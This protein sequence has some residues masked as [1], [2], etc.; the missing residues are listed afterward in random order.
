[1]ATKFIQNIVNS[2]TTLSNRA[3]LIEKQASAA[4]QNIVTGLELKV[5]EL[6]SKVQSLLDFAPDSSY[7]LKPSNKDFNASAW[8]QELQDTKM[9][10]KKYSDVLA[11]AQS[12][13]ADLFTEV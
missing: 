7:S 3:A 9:E 5:M 8:V 11:L 12:V 4:Q 13:Q 10:I 6:E 1:M 2:E